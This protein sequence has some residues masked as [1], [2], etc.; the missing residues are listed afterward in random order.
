[1]LPRSGR[2]SIPG[3]VREIDQEIG[4]SFSDETAR[5]VW[6]QVFVAN[7]RRDSEPPG[8]IERLWPVTC[9]ESFDRRNTRKAGE[10]GGKRN[11]F[12][13]GEQHLLVIAIQYAPLRIGQNGR[14]EGLKIRAAKVAAKA[15]HAKDEVSRL[16]WELGHP[17]GR[18]QTHLF[19]QPILDRG[20]RPNHDFG[21]LGFFRQLSIGS[22]I[23]FRLIRVPLDLDIDVS[24]NARH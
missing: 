16:R 1:M 24:L 14:V 7:K 8:E 2:P 13:E 15:A 19:G 23:I 21:P 9:R 5:K 11:V 12:T 3:I 10:H 20:F 6:H 22:K 18:E 17:L 4:F